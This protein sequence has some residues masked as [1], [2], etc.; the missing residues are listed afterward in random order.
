MRSLRGGRNSEPNEPMDAGSE[1][2]VTE[3]EPGDLL[4]EEMPRADTVTVLAAV[5][6]LPS[7]YARRAAV[8]RAKIFAV[9]AVLVALLIAAADRDDLL[10]GIFRQGIDGVG[11][12]EHFGEIA[13]FGQRIGGDDLAR[14]RN[15][16]GVDRGQSHPAA[17]YSGATS[18]SK[19]GRPEP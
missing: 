6:L 5:N 15:L 3:S 16:G 18:M 1:P 11:R 14:A 17:M 4:V 8:K 7:T 19:Q 12:A 10:G 2:G 13:L 9:G